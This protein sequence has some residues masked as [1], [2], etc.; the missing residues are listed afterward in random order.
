MVKVNAHEAGKT[1]VQRSGR[2]GGME[3][4]GRRL[5]EEIVETS[6]KRASS[7]GKRVWR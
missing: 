6:R 7:V 2:M 5:D 1:T 3:E 4:E